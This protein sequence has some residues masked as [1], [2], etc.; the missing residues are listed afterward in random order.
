M[1]DNINPLDINYYKNA[2]QEKLREIILNLC[3]DN[4]SILADINY[5]K[6]RYRPD[7]CVEKLKE[8][9]DKLYSNT[10][11]MVLLSNLKDQITLCN[12]EWQAMNLADPNSN[13]G[14]KAPNPLVE[15][16]RSAR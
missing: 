16:E 8:L 6:K 7:A 9:N 3:N 11:L 14:A 2:D 5:Y 1:S 13:M 12:R 15:S 4:D 10:A